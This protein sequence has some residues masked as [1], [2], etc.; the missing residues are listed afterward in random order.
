MRRHEPIAIEKIEKTRYLGHHTLCQTL[1]DIY[2]MTDNEDIKM[3]SR[4]AMSMA[5]SMHERL[6]K[7]RKIM[8]S[9]EI[10]AV[11]GDLST[12]EDEK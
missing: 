4:I 6:K 1:R 7:Y 9:K 10:E 12:Y 2:A 8:K 5:K 11:E 3:K